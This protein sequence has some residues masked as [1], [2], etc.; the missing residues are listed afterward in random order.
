MKREDVRSAAFTLAFFCFFSAAV[1]GESHEI[2]AGQFLYVRLLTPISS[3]SSKPGDPVKAILIAPIL[4]NESAFVP[5]GVVIE[6]QIREVRKV[7]LGFHHETARLSVEFDCLHLP[8]GSSVLIRTRLNEIDNSREEV[9]EGTI[10]G[11]RATNTPQGSI[12]SRLIHLPTWNPYSDTALI[13]FKLAFP[14]FPEPEINLAAGTD[15][16][17]QLL[18]PISVPSTSEQFSEMSC[19]TPPAHADESA[20]QDLAGRMPNRSTDGRHGKP[21]DLINLLLIGTEAE[22]RQAFKASGWVEAESNSFRAVLRNFYAF[23]SNSAYPGAPMAK[24]YLSGQPSAMNFQKAL[25][26]YGKRHHLRIW[27]T[28]LEFEGQPVWL[29]AATHDISATLSLRHMRFFHRVDPY[30]DLEREKVLRD[31]AYTGSVEHLS[32]LARPSI[33][34]P[35]V[36]ATGEFLATDGFLAAISL[37]DCVRCSPIPPQHEPTERPGRPRHWLVR[38][39]RSRV[40]IGRNDFL[41]ANIIYGAYKLAGIIHRGLQ[42]PVPPASPASDPSVLVASSSSTTPASPSFGR[43][44]HGTSRM[45]ASY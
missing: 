44:I 33:S 42:K 22:I 28:Q 11:V 45:E 29:A 18:E 3:Y 23:L 17:L 1:R 19:A 7:G 32:Y 37:K 36:N 13:A 25:N 26:S 31:L 35:L 14:V 6:G 21:A 24:F 41:R 27:S 39:V 20:L 9:R 8:D 43:A 10:K 5:E 34:S 15:F 40:L 30:I 4:H 12:N 16:S 38:Y 2:A